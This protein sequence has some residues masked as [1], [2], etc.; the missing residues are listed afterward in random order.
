VTDESEETDQRRPDEQPPARPPV[1]RVV[2]PRALDELAR[3]LVSAD[4][5]RGK[6]AI[7][8]R[9]V[10]RTIV[11]LDEAGRLAEHSLAGHGAATRRL[12]SLFRQGAVGPF[13][14]TDHGDRPVGKPPQAPIPPARHGRANPSEFYTMG[15]SPGPGGPH[16]YGDHPCT[17][18]FGPARNVLLAGLDHDIM[19]ADQVGQ[20]IQPARHT[21]LARSFLVDRAVSFGQYRDLVTDLQAGRIG[22]RQFDELTRVEGTL[23]ELEPLLY[24]GPGGPLPAAADTVAA[25]AP[26][27]FGGVPPLRGLQIPMMDAG[28]SI[29]GCDFWRDC[30]NAM[31]EIAENYQLGSMCVREADIYSIKPSAV[32]RGQTDVQLELRPAPGKNFASSGV[33]LAFLQEGLSHREE[34]KIVSASSDVITLEL[35]EASTSGCIGFRGPQSGSSGNVQL[36]KTCMHMGKIHDSGFIDLITGSGTPIHVW[37]D[38]SGRNRLEIVPPPVLESLHASAADSASAWS[39]DSPKSLTIKA[40]GCRDVTITWHFGF[41]GQE[42]TVHPGDYIRVRITDSAGN[43]VG[44]ALPH[45]GSVVVNQRDDETYT[46]LAVA[47]VEGESCAQDTATVGV[48]REQR[49]AL[50]GATLVETG[51]SKTVAVARSCP[52]PAGGTTV[53]LQS[54]NPARLQVPATVTIPEGA[55]SSA[56]ATITGDGAGC[57]TVSVTATADGHKPA[58]RDVLIYDVPVVSALVPSSVAACRQFTLTVHGTCFASSGSTVHLR[59]G[60]VERALN[61]SNASATTITCSLPPGQTLT[62][63]TWQLT[64]TARGLESQPASLVADPV[65]ATIVSFVGLPTQVWPCIPTPVN[66]VWEVRDDERV[67]VVRVQG[68]TTAPVAEA[69]SLSIC[70]STTGS[71]SD[72][73]VGPRQYQLRAFPAGGVGPATSNILVNEMVVPRA[74]GIR[75]TNP[76]A[77]HWRLWRYSSSSGAWTSTPVPGKTGQASSPSPFIDVTFEACAYQYVFAVNRTALGSDADNVGT[78]LSASDQHKWN[79]TQVMVPQPSLATSNNPLGRFHVLGDS[80]FNW[81]EEDV[82][83]GH[84]V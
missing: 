53:A 44:E 24:G 8:P 42:P 39:T 20:Q 75:L 29:A 57:S 7:V 34:L 59:H 51:H 35:A 77:S 4:R 43:V 74:G 61:V 16:S 45:D 11:E 81:I 68:T 2:S 21:M 9:W 73:A 84:G 64:V 54:S 10:N 25:E 47:E 67:T 36:I 46:L 52:S 48:Q 33:C 40:E 13:T 32:C 38:P 62:P 66:M 23:G 71:A 55:T 28:S 27:A 26:Q 17:F 65:P 78:S 15:G 5:R 14:R 18:E 19:W 79:L 70:G 56:A 37:C 3:L 76:S 50:A 30:A 82:V 69:T 72:T 22:A 83:V 6:E 41:G 1:V 58:T 63:G 31:V 60:D 12:V 49:L 80:T